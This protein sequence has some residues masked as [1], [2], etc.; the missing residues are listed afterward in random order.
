MSA[1]PKLNYLTPEEYLAIERR[2]EYKSEYV[3]GVMHAMAGGSLQH[4]SIAINVS[5]ELYIQ[6]KSTRCR[7]FNSDLK[8][9]VPSKRKYLYPDVTV[10][11][12]E[13][14]FDDKGD[15][16][17]SPLLIVEV[18]SKTTAGYDRRNKFLYYQEIES[19]QEYL[20]IAQ[21]Q[22]AVQH[23]VRQQ[24]GSWICTTIKGLDQ[25]VELTTVNCRLEL[26][27]IYDKV[28]I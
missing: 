11:C 6:L 22:A 28:A 19:F 21:D 25:S 9:R 4:S 15:A 17:L 18:L 5:G 1:V 27:D 12:A 14:Q 8:V 13:P 10:V 7:V 16:I 24:N 20:L 3:D 26:K 2:A 23:Y